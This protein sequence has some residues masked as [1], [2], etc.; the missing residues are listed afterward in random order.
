MNENRNRNR[1]RG[2]RTPDRRQRSR[3]TDERPIK[4]SDYV[5][6]RK[7]DKILLYIVIN[8]LKLIFRT[9]SVISYFSVGLFKIQRRVARHGACQGNESPSHRHIRPAIHGAYGTG[10]RSGVRRLDGSGIVLT[11]SFT[12]PVAKAL[13]SLK[14]RAVSSAA[15][16][17][18]R[19]V[20]VKSESRKAPRRWRDAIA[21]ARLKLQSERG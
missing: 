21:C 2:E 4:N 1:N 8:I 7:V 10:S 19:D 16:G 3:P 5:K 14:K 13:N 15:E 6:N 18:L 9:F 17:C 20:P 11:P 12:V